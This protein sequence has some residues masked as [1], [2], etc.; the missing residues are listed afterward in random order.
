MRG[1]RKSKSAAAQEKSR[2]KPKGTK[3]K[4]SHSRLSVVIEGPIKGSKKKAPGKPDKG[5]KKAEPKDDFGRGGAI[6]SPQR[7]G[8]KKTAFKRRKGEPDSDDEEL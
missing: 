2:G 6:L 5:K 8:M 3:N 4:M 7:V 1:G